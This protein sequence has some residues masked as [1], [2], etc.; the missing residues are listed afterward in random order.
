M[1]TLENDHNVYIIGAGFSAERGL[2][3]LA[4]FMLAMRDAHPWLMAQRREAEANSIQ[5]VLEYRLQAA[6]AGYRVRIE[7]ENIEE[8]FS[9]ASASQNRL[10]P[11]IRRAIAATLDYCQK[12]HSPKRARFVVVQDILPFSANVIVEPDKVGSERQVLLSMPTYEQYVGALL[13]WFQSGNVVGKNT[14]ISFNYDTL[15]EESLSGLGID[16]SYGFNPLSVDL[17]TDAKMFRLRH[18]AALRVLK[19]HGSCNWAR[20]VE[21]DQKLSIFDSYDSVRAKNLIPDVVPPTW[22]KVFGEQLNDVWSEALTAIGSATRVIMLGFS[23]PDTDLHFKYLLAAGLQNN[24]S[25]R[26]IVAVNP[27]NTTIEKRLAGMLVDSPIGF[28]RWIVIG[29]R[30]H[31]VLNPGSTDTTIGWYGRP[32]H[33]SIGGFNHQ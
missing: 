33:Q 16:F 23:M 6:S 25:L 12:V 24:F 29:H 4:N 1:S 28:R 31:T 2:P 5:K 19:L 8:L 17:N 27:D 11:D 3:V 9:L 21:T 13:G 22:R 32:I 15:V 14:F 7:L 18:D 26:Q 10:T 30:I 20:Q